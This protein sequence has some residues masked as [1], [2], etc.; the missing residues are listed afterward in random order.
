MLS[1]LSPQKDEVFNPLSPIGSIRSFPRVGQA[2]CQRRNFAAGY[3]A[4][5]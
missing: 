3:F 4:L 5:P 1:D 2:S